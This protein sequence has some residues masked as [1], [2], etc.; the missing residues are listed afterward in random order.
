MP[1]HPRFDENHRGRINPLRSP[2]LVACLALQRQR[3]GEGTPG[4]VKLLLPPR[5]SRGNSQLV[6]MAS[7]EPLET[8]FS[9]A[10]AELVTRTST[11]TPTAQDAREAL[12]VVLAAVAEG[13][14]TLAEASAALDLIEAARRAIGP[15][16]APPL[17]APEI[18]V[19]FVSAEH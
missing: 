3:L 14:I 2:N 15:E 13:G 11:R 17:V 16:A 7:A 9:M 4:N 12:N 5:Q 18:R 6:S 10:S 8:V 19:S 1:C